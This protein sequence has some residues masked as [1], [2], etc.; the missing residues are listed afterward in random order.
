MT[1]EEIQELFK[2]LA[3]LMDATQERSGNGT[4]WNYTFPNGEV[5]RYI[6]RNIKNINETE[7][8]IYNLILWIWNTKDYLKLRSNTNGHNFNNIEKF[9][10][11]DYYLCMCADLAN[12]LKHGQLRNS[13]S[14]N[15]PTLGRIQFTVPQSSIR[16]SCFRAFEVDIDPDP[17]GVELE[18]PIIDK[19]GNK[20]GDAFEYCELAIQRLEMIKN[21]IELSVQKD[22]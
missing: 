11:N 4:A 13:R 20:I 18:I 10:N 22:R 14:G 2:R 19:D 5:H 12:Y 21:E 17:R 7:D 8:D 15:F 16:N 3:R 6:I 9:I 1:E